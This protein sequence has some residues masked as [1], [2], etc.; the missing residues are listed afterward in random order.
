MAGRHA[1]GQGAQSVTT[2]ALALWSILH[3]AA[4]APSEKSAGSEQIVAFQPRDRHCCDSFRIEPHTLQGAQAGCCAAVKA[5]SGFV[6][7]PGVQLCHCQCDLLQPQAI[8]GHSVLQ[9]TAARLYVGFHLA[10]N[11]D[12]H[13]Q[14]TVCSTLLLPCVGGCDVSAISF[15]NKMQHHAQGVHVLQHELRV[16]RAPSLALTTKRMPSAPAIAATRECV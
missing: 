14:A 4:G 7:R 9:E 6:L 15:R 13:N 10:C 2:H 5:L 11:C 1:G 12:R 8:R 16:R 3:M